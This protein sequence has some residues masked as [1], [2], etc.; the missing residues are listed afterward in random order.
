MVSQSDSERGLSAEAITDAL[1]EIAGALRTAVSHKR[2][3]A[4]RYSQN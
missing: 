1:E 3:Y 4:E 2:Q